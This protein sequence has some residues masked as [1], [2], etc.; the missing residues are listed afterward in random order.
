MV[1]VSERPYRPRDHRKKL[2]RLR[3]GSPA[4]WIISGVMLHANHQETLRS[5]PL[6]CDTQFAPIKFNL[7]SPDV[8]GDD[9][10]LRLV[11]ARKI[12]EGGQF[13]PR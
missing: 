10:I 4:L 2:R 13:V 8:A 7:C 1:G 5:P 11:H 12:E 9:D 3:A 6:K